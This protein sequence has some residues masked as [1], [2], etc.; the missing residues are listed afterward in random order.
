METSNHTGDGST[1]AFSVSTNVVNEDNL[2]CFIDGVYQNKDT[3]VASGTTVTFDTAPVNNRKIVIYHVRSA[4]SGSSIVQDSFTGNGSTTD[5][6]LSIN[7]TSEL[8][9]QVYVD[10]VYQNK[11]TYTV[12]GT[13]LAFDTAP[14]NTTAIEVIIMSQTA[15]NAPTSNSVTTSTIV[16]GNVTTAKILDANVTTAKLADSSVTSAKIVDGTIATGDIADDA[17]TSAKLDTNI[18]IAGNFDVAGNVDFNGNLDVDGT[19]N[20]DVVDIDGAVDMASTLSVTGAITGTLA[21]A[22]QPNITS[23]GTLI[24]LDVAG[25]ATFSSTVKTANGSTSAPAYS[26]S[27][28]TDSGMFL[29]GAG[30]LALTVAGSKQLELGGGIIYTASTGKIRSA[31]NSGTLE[32]SGGGAQVGGQILLSGGAS[33]GNVIFKTSLGSS[34]ATEVMRIKETGAIEITGTST[35]SQAQAF[36]TN[37]NSVLTIGSSV[38]G[39]VVKDIAFNSPSTMM[40][41]DGSTAN[42]GIGTTSPS[43]NITISNGLASAPTSITAANS[44]IQIGSNDYGSG[45]LGKFMIGFGYTDVLVNTHS[46]AYIGYEE[47]ST[48]GDTKGELTFYTRDVITDTAPT[49]RMRIGS[50]GVAHFYGDVKVLTGDIQMGNGRGINFSPTSDATGMT[51]ETLDDYEEGTWT[52]AYNNGG[53]IAYSTQYGSYVKIGRLVHLACNIDV[54][55]VSGTNSGQMQITGAPF[56]NDGVDET[57]GSVG[58]NL[59][60]WLNGSGS[61]TIQINAT[62]AAILPSKDTKNDIYRGTDIGT[63]FVRWS[64]VYMTDE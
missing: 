26:F 63:G 9:T 45:A 35:T 6:T 47:T 18:A 56:T 37:D 7:P 15:V 5:F 50:D 4:V 13:T 49:E 34:T 27:A 10:G 58:I 16:D 14:V 53:S 61:D 60:G 20:L 25:T 17:V 48:S 44:Y 3:F 29:N 30:Y 41:I 38:S 12:S 28:D 42:V 57:G 23:V 46:P 43:G 21:T 24:G 39:S 1:R 54:N 2:V 33:D 11:S 62:D 8:N 31:T 22:S 52:P 40:Y 36:I 32:L 64:I 19:T 55:T 59:S 51:S